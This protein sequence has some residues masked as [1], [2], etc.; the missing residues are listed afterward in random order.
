M[1]FFEIVMPPAVANSKPRVFT[2]S[3]TVAIRVAP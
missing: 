3:S 2:M 1:S